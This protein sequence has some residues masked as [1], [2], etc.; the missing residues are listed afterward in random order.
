MIG[1]LVFIMGFSTVWIMWRIHS[2][3]QELDRC[4]SAICQDLDDLRFEVMKE[5]LDG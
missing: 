4:M 3:V 5:E 1:F 2:K